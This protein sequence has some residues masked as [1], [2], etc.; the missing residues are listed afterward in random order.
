VHTEEHS[1]AFGEAS[2]NTILIAN[3][4]ADTYGAD[5]QMLESVSAM[6]AQGWKV[7]VAIPNRGNL[8]ELIEK[9][10]GSVHI[11]HFPVLRRA[12]ASAGGV[13]R[14]ARAALTSLVA[15][16]REIRAVSPAAVYVN[17]ITLPWWILGGRLS[18]IPV[19]VHVHEAET[20]DSRPVRFALNAP[21]LL[22]NRLILI[23]RS[24]KEATIGAVPGL[25]RRSHLVYNGVTRLPPPMARR[26]IEPSG[27]IRIVA[28]CRLSPRKAPDVA[29]ESVAILRAAGLDVRLDLCGTPFSGYEWFE[30]QLRARAARD[31][32]AGS[33]TFSGY[34]A[35]IWS[36]LDVADIVVA[37]SLREPFGNAVVEAQLS[38][39]PVVASAA[40]GHTE[41]IVDEESGLLVDPG[42]SRALAKAIERIV[43]DPALAD[44]LAT[45]GRESALRNF[46]HD[47]YAREIVG[48]L[49]QLIRRRDSD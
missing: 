28:V 39:R 26:T 3:P 49:T 21:L 9:R 17:T 44:H 8:V 29:L 37:P 33:I 4:S 45:N 34:V 30:E 14:L 27:P 19:V 10:G 40:T 7:V 48:I 41:S 46:S 24:T 25:S 18:R 13:W 23:S 43:L 16:R 31:D 2:V 36:A 35:P 22:A 42:D 6:I 38:A 11:V 20:Q 32:L 47:R 5:L 1:Q 15:I 12:S